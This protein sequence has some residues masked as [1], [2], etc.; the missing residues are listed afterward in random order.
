[1]VKSPPMKI[2]EIAHSLSEAVGARAAAADRAGRL[3]EEDIQD[4]REAGY[5]GLNI[6]K[7][8]GGFGLGMRDTV[9]AQLALSRGS[10]STAIVAAMQFQ[11]FGNEQLARAW[12]DEHFEQFSRAAAQGA[13]FNS[14]ASEPRMG[15]PS[16]GGLPETCAQQTPEGWQLSGRKTWVTGGRHLTHLLVR[17]R[18]EDQ[19]AVVLVENGTPGVVWEETWRQ[20][21][22]LRAS[23]SHDVYFENVCLPAENLI[24]RGSGRAQ[25]NPWFPM[26]LA[27]VYLGVGLGARDAAIRYALERV[28]T[29]LGKPIASLP[30]IQR[31]IGEIDIALRAARSLL[32]ETAA[33][34]DNEPRPAMPAIT[35]AKQFACQAAADVTEQAL[36]LAGG[37]ALGPGLPFERYFRD[38]RAGMMQPPSGDTAFEALGRAAID[39]VHENN[40]HSWYTDG[41]KRQAGTE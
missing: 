12:S 37:A 18:I 25:P 40:V 16:R 32:L 15:S 31:Q 33:R 7:E 24:E 26:M 38:A 11:V 21:L 41:R 1:M 13:L 19:H 14:A 28:P 30:K 23:D 27:S 29:A 20:A 34:W 39:S 8:F 3:P 22:S 5:L 6:P 35:A 9:D 4:L 2:P 10:A 17:C 36:Q